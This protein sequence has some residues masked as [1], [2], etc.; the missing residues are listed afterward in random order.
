M[1][2]LIL[3]V[4]HLEVI[5]GYD[6]TNGENICI[7]ALVYNLFLSMKQ[8]FIMHCTLKKVLIKITF[9]STKKILSVSTL[10]ETYLDNADYI[11][12]FLQSSEKYLFKVYK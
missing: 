5:C 8:W 7:N 10:R 1:N 6:I 11:L 3:F 4:I 9:C 2:F 12:K